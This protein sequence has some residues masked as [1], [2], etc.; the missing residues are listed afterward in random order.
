ML[1]FRY[2][3]KESFK[4][5][6]AVFA[7]L[8]TIFLSQQFVQVLAEASE[9]ELPTGLIFQ[10][11]GLQV[12][13]LAALILPISLFLG[14]LLAHGRLYTD[15]EMSVLHACGISEWYVTRITLVFALVVALVTGALTLWGGP[16]ALAQQERLTESA[17]NEAG[18]NVIQS[19][20][21]QAIADKRGVMFVESVNSD[22]QLQRVF[23]A[24]IPNLDDLENNNLDVRSSV[25]MASTGEIQ[26]AA[27]GAQLLKLNDGRR[28]SQSLRFLDHQVMSFDT[29][30]MQIRE[31]DETVTAQ[32][33]ESLTT[34]ELLADNSAQANAELQWRIAIPLAMPLLTLIAV[35]LSRVNP[36]QGKFARMAPAILIYLGYFMILMAT[37]RAI[38]AERVPEWLGLWWVHFSLLLIGVSLLMK[39]RTLGQ[40]TWAKLT[41]RLQ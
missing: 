2:L 15:H 39:D 3:I 32:E 33:F 40:K 26:E 7:V 20:R 30:Q 24:Q 34:L 10:V 36:R 28:Y 4:A 1:I 17:Q 16:L 31:R 41:R 11:V 18:L 25:V 14:I 6:I 13:G 29:Y 37:K 22:Q 35:P 5:Q 8:M 21:F 23:L 38:G 12:P 19:G 27:N 9:G